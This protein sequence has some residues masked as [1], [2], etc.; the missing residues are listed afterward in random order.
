MDTLIA[1]I[2]VYVYTAALNKGVQY[3]F[4]DPSF[5]LGDYVPKSG[6]SGS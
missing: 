3:V 5:N 4:Q 1:S 2:F 6:I